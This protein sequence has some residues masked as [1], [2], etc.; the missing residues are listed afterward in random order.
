MLPQTEELLVKRRNLLEKKIAE[1]TEKAR[2]YTRAKNQ[3]GGQP[4]RIPPSLFEL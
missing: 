3:R 4:A 2:E 1:A